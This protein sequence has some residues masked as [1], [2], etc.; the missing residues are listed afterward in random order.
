MIGETVLDYVHPDDAERL[1]R[2]HAEVRKDPER[3]PTVEIRARHKDGS[4]RRLE[5]SSASLLGDA[6]APGVV[7][8]VRDVASRENTGDLFR[9][10][11]AT[12][13][14]S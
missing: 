1:V 5:V 7:S 8:V 4:W 11:V 12:P 13:Q 14:R 6:S 10:V 3:E 9:S 2:A